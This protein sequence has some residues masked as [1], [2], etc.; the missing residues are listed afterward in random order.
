MQDATMTVLE[1]VIIFIQFAVDVEIWKPKTI[2]RS[3][4]SRKTAADLLLAI[5]KNLRL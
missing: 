5:S 2:T 3:P 4:S 1:L